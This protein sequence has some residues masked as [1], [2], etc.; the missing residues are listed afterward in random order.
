MHYFYMSAIQ[1]N[2]IN[3]FRTYPYVLQATKELEL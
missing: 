2:I 1:K 3:V